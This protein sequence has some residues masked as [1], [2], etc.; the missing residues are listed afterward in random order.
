MVWYIKRAS[1]KYISKVRTANGTWRYIYAD[2]EEKKKVEEEEQRKYKEQ[3]PIQTAATDAAS[4][5]IL[6]GGMAIADNIYKEANRRIEKRH[7]IDKMRE[8]NKNGS[9]RK[10]AKKV[11]KRG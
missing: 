1:Y 6:Y 5:A 10:A 2:D 3:H 7:S 11:Y 8:L 9:V 4:R